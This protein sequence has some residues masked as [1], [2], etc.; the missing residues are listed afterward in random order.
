MQQSMQDTQHF[1]GTLK[2]GSFYHYK[3]CHVQD[4]EENTSFFTSVS[5]THS[6]LQK[7]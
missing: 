4:E 7:Y 1:A 2:T 5:L 3:S 6:L